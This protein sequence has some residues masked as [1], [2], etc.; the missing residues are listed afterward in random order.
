MLLSIKMRLIW[1]KNLNQ[2][3][4]MAEK[5]NSKITSIRISNEHHEIIK[6][7]AFMK[8]KPIYE[9]LSEIFEK[10]LE[11]SFAKEIEI[12]KKQFS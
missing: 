11:S 1:L 4:N 5:K 9:I 3:F 12:Y 10:G 7:I 8:K 2:N 6:Y